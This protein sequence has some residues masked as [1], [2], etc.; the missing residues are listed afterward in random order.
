MP[1]Q[2]E[3]Q[4]GENVAGIW[5]SKIQQI[6]RTCRTQNDERSTIGTG[7]PMPSSRTPEGFRGHCPICQND[8]TIEPSETPVRDAPCP[9]CGH[10]LWFPSRKSLSLVEHAF[11]TALGGSPD[12]GNDVVDENF[13]GVKRLVVKLKSILQHEISVQF[14][15]WFSSP[16]SIFVLMMIL[17]AGVEIMLWTFAGERLSL[18]TDTLLFHVTMSLTYVGGIDYFRNCQSASLDRLF[19]ARLAYLGSILATLW[20]LFAEL[21]DR[22]LVFSILLAG[23][24]CCLFFLIY[25]SATL[26]QEFLPRRIVRWFNGERLNGGETCC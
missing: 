24:W 14:P 13:T 4:R 11:E 18:T 3:V 15:N 23:I 10:L 21:W 19:R 16:I 17:M 22:L 7:F 9:N 1:P 12:H 8:V 25:G 2:M 5:G 6:D 20:L 26:L